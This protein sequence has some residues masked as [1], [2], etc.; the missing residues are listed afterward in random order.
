MVETHQHNFHHNTHLTMGR[1]LVQRFVPITGA[2][3]VQKKDEKDEGLWH[4]LPSIT[5]QGGGPRS[6]V[7]IPSN[8]RH[9]FTLLE[10]NGFYR[11]VF[12]H[13]DADGNVCEDDQGYAH[14]RT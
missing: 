7:P 1:W 12:S 8:M 2:D 6:I 11:C 3:G 13:R 9:K 4:E 5:I 14:G 10:G